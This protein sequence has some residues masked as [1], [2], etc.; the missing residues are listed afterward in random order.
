MHSVHPTPKFSIITVTYNAEKVLEDTI[1]SVISQTYHHIEYII[2]DGASK[3]G[4]L[5]IINRYRPHI[6]T[7]VSEPDKGLYDAMNKGIALASGDYLCFLNAGDC[8][9]EDDT[10]QQM[11]HT[12]NGSELPDVLYG[13]TAIVDQ[14]R[15]FLRMRRLSAPETLTWKSFKQGMLVCHQAFFP[16]HTLVEPYNLKY[17]FSADFDWCIRIMKKAR[18]LHNTH[19]TII[20]YLDEGMTTRNQKASLKERF[21]IM[22]KHYG[23]IGTVAHHIWFVIRAVIHR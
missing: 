10:L 6:H 5:S 4:T 11:V 15:H 13:E 16:R 23:L 20:D 14:D 2:V 8:F 7:V 12:I 22:A 3:D 19:L 1:Q 21:R 9:H 18:T 17:R